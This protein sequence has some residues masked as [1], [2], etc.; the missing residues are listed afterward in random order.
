MK[1][2]LALFAI[3]FI[4]CNAYAAD[5]WTT[6]GHINTIYPEKSNKQVLLVHEKQGAINICSGTDYAVL[7]KTGNEMFSEFYSLLLMAY[8]SGK[9]VNINFKGCNFQNR[10]IVNLIKLSREYE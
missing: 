2:I 4:S 6:A 10:P 8:A 5:Q 9:K 7:E 3:Y 1:K